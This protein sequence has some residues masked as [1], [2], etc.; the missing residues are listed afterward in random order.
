MKIKN[1][2]RKHYL[3]N[4]LFIDGT[5]YAGKSTMCRM[6][7]EKYEWNL[8][9]ENYGMDRLLK[10]ITPEE[11]PNSNYFKI[12][13]DWQ[14]F[15]NRTP[16]DYLDWIL[17][18]SHE[19]AGFEIAELIRLSIGAASAAG[20]TAFTRVYAQFVKAH[21]P[22]CFAKMSSVSKRVSACASSLTIVKKP[23][24]RHSS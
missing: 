22:K 13:K 20:I 10:L 16:E 15:I 7:A 19:V 1:N 11:Q 3:K 14:E 24:L 21:S 5:A 18:S 2:I 6:L 4:C 23:L 12:M 17:G 8:F 9:G